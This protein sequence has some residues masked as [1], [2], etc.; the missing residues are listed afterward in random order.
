MLDVGYLKM[1]DPAGRM[2]K[3]GYDNVSVHQETQ[4]GMA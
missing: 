4:Q 1:M 3:V 2:S